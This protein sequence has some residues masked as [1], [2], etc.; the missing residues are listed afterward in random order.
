[1]T[2]PLKPTAVV[3]GVGAE[4]GLGAALCRKFA[5]QGYH[6]LVA[7]RTGAKVSQ[8]VQTLYAR[9]GSGEAIITDTTKEADVV[10]L[11]ERAL[12]PGPGFAPVDLVVFNAGNNR[13]VPF[14]ELDAA[15]FEDFWRV[16]CFGGFLVG[17]EAARAMVPLGRGTVLFTGASA[18]LR[19]KPGFAQFA[20]AKAGL[21]MIS[22]SMARE[23]GPQG[24][25]VAHVIIDGGI[26]GERLRSLAPQP[27]LAREDD[28]LLD[29][30]A[31][32]ETYWQLHRQHRSAWTQEVDLRPFKESF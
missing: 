19:G 27:V 10:S 1:M 2:S 4:Q 16:G 24:L 5:A 32:A 29:I 17:R 25:H 11:F 23:L 3:V 6:V 14:R 26:N 30:D 18:S 20:A 22:Q 9:Q 28:G 13:K 21:R 12:S 7:G 15:Q 8:V 31:I